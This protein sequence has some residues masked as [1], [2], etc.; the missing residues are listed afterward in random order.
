MMHPKVR[1]LLLP[2]GLLAAMSAFGQ[3]PPPAQDP[4]I[5][6]QEVSLY[7]SDASITAADFPLILQAI[8][9]NGVDFP[10]D[11]T[12]LERILD[13]ARGGT[14]SNQLTS[15][16]VLQ[17]LRGCGDCRNR[18]FGPLNKEELISFIRR[19]EI[20]PH[21]ALEEVRL[22][23]TKDIPKTESTIQELQAAGAAPAL[24]DLVVPDDEVE[25]SAPAGYTAVPLVR[26]LDY[27]RGREAGRLDL[28]LDVLGKVELLFVNNALFY[29]TVA[30][31]DKKAL[32]PTLALNSGSYNAPTPSDP[33]M[34]SLEFVQRSEEKGKGVK[35]MFENGKSLMGKGDK[36]P[37]VE[38]RPNAVPGRN[39]FYIMI[40]EPD[41]K[42]AHTYDIRLTWGQQDRAK[43]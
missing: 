3:T 33:V 29:K 4:P 5:S 36:L 13:A 8:A 9:R 32:E 6:L 31:A 43:P 10:L 14:R 39:G 25:I 26:S 41:K 20:L 2:C 30:N 7:L 16:V 21:I 22:R 38:F 18:Y 1:L 28:N 23:G 42:Q 37:V 12:A 24:I 19:K 35:K 11:Q 40:D 27:L 34:P 15:A 17:V